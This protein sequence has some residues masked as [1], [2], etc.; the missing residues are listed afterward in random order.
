MLGPPPLPFVEMLL[1]QGQTNLLSESD[2][3]P[4]LVGV[5]VKEK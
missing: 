3:P 1:G 4:F 2:E 5:T